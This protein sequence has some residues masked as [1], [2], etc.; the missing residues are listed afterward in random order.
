ML[1]R[2]VQLLAELNQHLRNLNLHRASGLASAAQTRCMRQMMIGREAVVERREHGADRPGI[3]TA[4]SMAADGTIDRAGIQTRTAAD[5]EQA[6]AQRPAENS[7][8]AVVENHE[9]KL[10]RPF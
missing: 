2:L 7:R 9:M 5:A 4:I 8:A 10:F 3:D 1:R 6:F